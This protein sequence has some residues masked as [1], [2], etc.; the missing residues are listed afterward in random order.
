MKKLLLS[1]LAIF[2]V[3]GLVGFGTYAWFQDTETSTGNT[4]TAGTLDLQVRDDG[5]ADP[6]PWGDGVDLTWVMGNMIP[7]VSTVTN[8][9][10]LR[11]VGSI[12][13]DH[14][15]I[16]F[17]NAID[18]LT[19]PVES[20]TDP[21]SDPEDLAKWI[22]ITSMTYNAVDLKTDI[23]GTGGY[24]VNGNGWLDLDDVA[25]SAPVIAE[26]G[27]LDDLPTP[28]DVGGEVT[29]SM[30]LRFRAEATNDIQGDI[31]TT[32]VTFTLNQDSSQ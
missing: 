30:S 32:T 15:E 25:R 24:D 3:I 20:D 2:L 18:E 31:L 27:P 5:I 7:G 22:E 16:S 9:V 17:S 26:G 1:I 23:Q 21:G 19:N 12:A 10:T 13:G 28:T 4:F 29:L 6:D 11:N 8:T 14:V